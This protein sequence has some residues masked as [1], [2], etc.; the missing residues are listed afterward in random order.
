VLDNLHFFNKCCNTGDA[1]T[2]KILHLCITG[3]LVSVLIICSGPNA[4]AQQ[5][6][7]Q[8]NLADSSYITCE[9]IWLSA[10]LKNVSDDTVRIWGFEFPGGGKLKVILTDEGGDTL[11]PVLDMFYGGWPG[12]ILGP[13]ETYSEAFD[14]ARIFWNH[15]ISSGPALPLWAGSLAPGTYE[16]AAEYLN[17]SGRYTIPTEVIRFKVTEPEGSE[18]EAFNLFLEGYRSW[19]SGNFHKGNDLLAK[20]IA[21]HPKSVYAERV[22]HKFGRNEELLNKMPDSGYLNTYLYWTIKGMNDE[23]E[24]RSFLEGIIQEHPGTRVSRFA[25]ERLQRLERGE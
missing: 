22:Y 5:L 19:S 8:I 2:V 23:E 1:R 10:E 13:G 4:L 16:V 15:E 14:L 21:G 9:T 11:K 7:F 18:L 3:V 6:E 24:K 25:Q 17:R 20:L 12:F